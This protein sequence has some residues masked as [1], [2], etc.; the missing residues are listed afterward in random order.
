MPA[1][2]QVH[3]QYQ[4]Q[5]LLVLAIN[6]TSQDSRSNALSFVEQLKL[7]FPIL[8]DEQGEVFR[9]YE[10][11]A[12]PTTFFVDRQGFIREVIIGGPM[13]EVLLDIRVQQLFEGGP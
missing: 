13:S 3:R 12:L 10:V 7:S 9:L 1:I 2:E 5:G 6:A 8:F 11:Q 4:G